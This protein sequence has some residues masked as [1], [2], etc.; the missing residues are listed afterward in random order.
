MVA[1][2]IINPLVTSE[3][4]AEARGSVSEYLKPLKQPYLLTA[5]DLPRHVPYGQA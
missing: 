3:D 1:T 2:C 4:L 5:F